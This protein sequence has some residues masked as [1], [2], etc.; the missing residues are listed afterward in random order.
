MSDS[1]GAVSDVFGGCSQ[2]FIANPVEDTKINSADTSTI[3]EVGL[4]SP[5]RRRMKGGVPRPVGGVAGV[6]DRCN[7][8]YFLT[9]SPAGVPVAR[10]L[11]ILVNFLSF[12]AN[13]GQ[14][15]A[16]YVLGMARFFFTIYSTHFQGG[17]TGFYRAAHTSA[18]KSMALASKIQRSLKG[19]WLDSKSVSCE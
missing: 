3:D 6:Q 5:P 2:H 19:R 12:L 9:W 17:H 4:S 15:R 10:D 7:L 16:K 8:V 14:E 11:D 1:A 18:V 13:L